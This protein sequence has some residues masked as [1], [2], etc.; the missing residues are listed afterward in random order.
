M[1]ELYVYLVFNLCLLY[2]QVEHKLFLLFIKLMLKRVAKNL[3]N[4]QFSGLI[5][6]KHLDALVLL[7]HLLV[8]L[9]LVEVSAFDI[10]NHQLACIFHLKVA[11]SV[12]RILHEG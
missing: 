11:L 8:E 6:P 3:Q 2:R 1:S 5:E 9:Y 7:Y 4:I 12:H 10:L